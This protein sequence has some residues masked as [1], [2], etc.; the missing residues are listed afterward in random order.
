VPLPH[1]PSAIRALLLD[2]LE[3]AG[4]IG[5]RLSTRA[6]SD[7]TRPYGIVQ[8]P[9]NN[10]LGAFGPF[11]KP[12]V[13]VEG[14]LGPDPTDTTAPI[15]DPEVAVWRIAVRAAEVLKAAQYVTYADDHG[16]MTYKARVFEGPLPR[17]DTTRGP[18]MPVFG[19]LVRAEL[20]LGAS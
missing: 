11:W 18:S 1:I 20:T 13:Q 7:V 14:W 4:L 3:F 15:E 6:P 9:G 16:A 2:D 12:I 19:C 17:T 5:G 10:P 8:A